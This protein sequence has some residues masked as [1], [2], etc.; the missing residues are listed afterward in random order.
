MGDGAGRMVRWAVGDGPV[1]GAVVGEVGAGAVC[2]GFDT[3]A[4]QFS[5]PKNWIIGVVLPG[6]YNPLGDFSLV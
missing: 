6:V 2:V 3:E 5:I 1:G 4:L